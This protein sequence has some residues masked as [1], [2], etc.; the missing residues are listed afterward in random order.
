MSQV[1]ITDEPVLDLDH[2]R[3]ATS[4]T[5]CMPVQ[6][7]TGMPQVSTLTVYFQ[8]YNKKI[9]KSSMS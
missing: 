9:N 7:G 2:V 6:F 8:E 3:E 5:S 4:A 1:C